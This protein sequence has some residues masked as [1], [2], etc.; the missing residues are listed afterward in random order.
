MRN[1]NLIFNLFADYPHN[2]TAEQKEI[3]DKT[4]KESGLKKILP[5]LSYAN[6]N[7]LKQSDTTIDLSQDVI[8]L[9]FRIE[10]QVRTYMALSFATLGHSGYGLI[11][12]FISIITIICFIFINLLWTLYYVEVVLMLGLATIAIPFA[13]LGWAIPF[14]YIKDWRLKI[15]NIFKNA[16]L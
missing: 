7:I 15:L 16:T 11:K 13:L 1:V 6:Q 14:P 9:F 5:G 4:R 12:G 10:E 3:F 8:C 2:L